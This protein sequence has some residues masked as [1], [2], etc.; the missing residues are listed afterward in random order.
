MTKFV[1]RRGVLGVA[2]E[3]SRGTA[4]APVFWLGWAKMAFFD[5]AEKVAEA[6][7]LGQIADQ[8]SEYVTQKYGEGS[9]DAQ[10]YDNGL[11]YILM[12]LL[13][14]APVT[15][16]G[17]PYTHT[18]TMS[19]TN[20]AQSLSLYWKDPDR[21]YMFRLGI[22]DSLKI[23]VNM[24]GIV[25]YSIG[26]KS[27]ASMDYASQTAS[28]TAMG[29]KFLHQHLQFRLASAIA[30]LAGASEIAIKQLE[31]TI[32]RNT[33]FDSGL[34][35]VEPLD[36]LSQSMSVEGQVTLNLNDDTYRNLMLNGTYNAME[37]K[38]LNSTSSSLQMQFPR[39]AFNSWEPDYSLDDIATQQINFKGNYDAA[40]ALDIISTCVLINTKSSY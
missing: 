20:Q 11:G 6:Q 30:G 38:L 23:T 19:Q 39:M 10:I 3:S 5:N 28:F 12:S 35:T 1:S 2:K 8:D 7:G 25:E 9:V 34:G 31:L 21:S 37:I 29:S 27:K 13:G 17:N 4:V 36:I 24:N 26:F 32:S 18:F 22:V 16:G 40:N 33:T 14:A 15:T